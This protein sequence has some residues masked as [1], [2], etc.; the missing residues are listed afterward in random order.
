MKSTTMLI[1]EPTKKAKTTCVA[2]QTNATPFT[3][4]PEQQSLAHTSPLT[5]S[6]GIVQPPFHIDAM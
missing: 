6:T 1:A 4:S 3:E 2:L 5:V